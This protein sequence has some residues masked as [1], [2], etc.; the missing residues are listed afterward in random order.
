MSLSGSEVDPKVWE[1]GH[2]SYT[3]NTSLWEVGTGHRSPIEDRS[4]PKTLESLLINARWYD[5]VG[6]SREL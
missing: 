6:E 1:H 2:A 3:S 4:E 5:A